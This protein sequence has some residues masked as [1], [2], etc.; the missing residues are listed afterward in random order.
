MVPPGGQ[1]ATHFRK[2]ESSVWETCAQLALRVHALVKGCPFIHFRGN[3][4]AASPDTCGSQL[5]VG[6][7]V[8]PA[9][10]RWGTQTWL[11]PWTFQDLAAPPFLVPF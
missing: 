5:Q 11:L 4:Q 2:T 9:L 8:N 3:R 10:A 6:C 1:H 7:L